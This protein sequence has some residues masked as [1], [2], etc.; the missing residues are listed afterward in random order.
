MTSFQFEELNL[1][2]KIIDLLDKFSILELS[3]KDEFLTFLKWEFSPIE[4][5]YSQVIDKVLEI[6]Y[7]FGVKLNLN[8][9]IP[10]YKEKLEFELNNIIF[11]LNTDFSKLDTIVQAC[12]EYFD[13]YYS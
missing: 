11:D 10:K 7:Y 8:L 2:L 3:K 4:D 5:E 13:D 1:S 12:I 9:Q 6:L